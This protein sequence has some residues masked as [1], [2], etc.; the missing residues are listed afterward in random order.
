M[1]V[2]APIPTRVPAGPSRP[3]AAVTR[4]RV[5]HP[6]LLD[7]VLGMAVVL[8]LSRFLLDL[9]GRTPPGVAALGCV[10]AAAIIGTWM[11]WRRRREAG[12]ASSRRVAI[13]FAVVAAAAYLLSNSLSS[14]GVQ[15]V[16][17]LVLTLELGV[18]ASLA[19][20]ALIA[21]TT[22]AIHALLGTGLAQGMLE[23]IGVTLLLVVGIE[24][25]VLLRSAERLDADRLAALDAAERAN[26]DLAAANAQL[27]EANADLED[28]NM[29][30]R[31]ERGHAQDLALAEERARIATALHD[32]LGHRL[33]AIGLSL[34]YSARMREREPERAAAEVRL[35]RATASDA[36]EEMRRVVRAMHPVTTDAD[37]IA[38]SLAA[39]AQSF[40]S[41][42][43]EVAFRREGT[44]GI[45]REQGLLLLR[46]AQEGLTNVVRHAGA[47]RAELRLEHEGPA[48]RLLVLDDGRG[49]D[50]PG[51]PDAP[52]GI[53]RG[54]GLRS[55]GE[56][57]Q[58][59]GGQVGIA[60]G[61]G[62]ERADGG[63]GVALRLD[64]PAAADRE[65]AA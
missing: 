5:H 13:A 35:A 9:S 34:D 65:R 8:F 1:P 50:V 10:T 12:T 44:G 2:P 23:G 49:A 4:R 45:G 62:L 52:P 21:T 39:L 63:A 61:A 22:V 53:T 59:H 6:A 7:V 20:A 30:L 64:L 28:A 17:T 36:L 29:Q 14:I 40:A 54:F 60:V 15:W 37:D 41:T 48:V 3:E 32:G 47:S 33:T 11:L 55:M 51:G 18:L 42:G 16:A 43:L 57:A 19:Y 25:A 24:F 58:L 46:V 27:R 31:R 56:R 38:G 26:A